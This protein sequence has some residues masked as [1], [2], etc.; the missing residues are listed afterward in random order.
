MFVKTQFGTI[1]NLAKFDK[2]KI[3]WSV[4]Q[5]SETTVHIISAVSDEYSCHSRVGD[6]VEEIKEV[7][8]RTYKSETLA[9]FPQDMAEQ[10]NFACH[11]LFNALLN[12]K[13]VFDMTG[14]LGKQAK[15]PNPE[16]FD[17]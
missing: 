10:A 2:I 6:N 12:R 14:Y 5:D 9:Q 11:D 3:E 17:R 1:V 4:K 7:P 13:S 16:Q 15:K 8:V